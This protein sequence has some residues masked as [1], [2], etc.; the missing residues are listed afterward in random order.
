MKRKIL[1]SASC[2]VLLILSVTTNAQNDPESSGFSAGAD[3]YSSYVW[4][5]T[6]LGR[7]P[8]F[9]PRV[10]FSSGGLTAGVWG[11]FDAL[12][13]TEA[14]PYISYAFP[15]GLIFGVTDYYYPDLP[16][17]EISDS[18]GSHAVEMN[19]GFGI[20]GISLSANVILNEAGGTGSSGGDMYFEARYDF[21]GV[22]LFIGAGD[23]WHTSDGNFAVCNI[24]VGI[25]REIILS[26]NFSL[27]VNGQVILNPEQEHFYVVVG[28]S[29]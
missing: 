11:S 24:G 16:V 18:T 22:S 6:K 17:F 27:P 20:G 8:A 21:S 25:F 10:D 29:L 5:G 2:F 12:G 19:F 14:D 3:F 13:Y 23:G 4:R 9:Q 26:D 15:F 28:F 1:L 7:G